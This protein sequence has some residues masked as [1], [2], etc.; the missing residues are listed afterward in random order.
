MNDDLID[1]SPADEGTKTIKRSAVESGAGEALVV[2]TL[3]DQLPPVN[4]LRLYVHPTGIVLNLVR[5][6]IIS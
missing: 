5:R 3:G 1:L 6:E 2:E 4:D